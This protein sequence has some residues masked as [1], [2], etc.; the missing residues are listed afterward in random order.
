M[1]AANTTN[2][3]EAQTGIVLGFITLVGVISALAMTTLLARTA[4]G[5]TIP[6]NPPTEDTLQSLA[7]TTTAMT[8]GFDPM[9]ISITA[10][11]IAGLFI[12]AIIKHRRT[13]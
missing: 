6:V 12:T 13:A 3:P 4:Q 1:H 11:M 9:L 10:A 7:T 5:S 8:S 2:T